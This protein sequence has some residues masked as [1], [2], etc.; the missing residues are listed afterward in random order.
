MRKGT[1]AGWRESSAMMKRTSSLLQQ[2]SL[3]LVPTQHA[4]FA[5]RL[6]WKAAIDGKGVARSVGG[7]VQHLVRA[8]TRARARVKDQGYDRLLTR[9][10][11][12]LAGC[13]PRIMLRI[14][15][16]EITVEMPRRDAISEASVD[17]PLPEVPPKR[18]MR[19]RRRSLR[20]LATQKCTRVSAAV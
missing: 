3:C 12:S 1:T 17:L 19:Q 15:S 9:L 18:R 11:T 4:L 14:E 2:R 16:V 6:W 10:P 7:L 8:R 5:R 20:S 13:A